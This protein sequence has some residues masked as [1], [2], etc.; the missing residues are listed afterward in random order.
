MRPVQAAAWQSHDAPNENHNH[1]MSLFY[2]FLSTPLDISDAHARDVIY[3]IRRR[4]LL[5]AAFLA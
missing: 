5:W 1:A 2:V 4:F 3:V